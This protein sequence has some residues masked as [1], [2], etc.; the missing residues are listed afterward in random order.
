[1]SELR[2]A[3]AG[4]SAPVHSLAWHALMLPLEA[5]RAVGPPRADLFTWYE[6]VEYSRRLR[7]AGYELRVVHAALVNHP[8]PPRMKVVRLPGATLH[9]P[10]ATPDRAYLMTRNSLVVHREF[11]GRRFWYADLP[12]ILIKAVVIA[13]SLPGSKLANLRSV[14]W[15]PVLDAA[16]GRMGPPPGDARG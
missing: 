10:I 3:A 8:P 14:L 16:R 6:D 4:A 12:A 5:V 7:R 13:F 1:M 9:V 2:A 15:Q 11:G